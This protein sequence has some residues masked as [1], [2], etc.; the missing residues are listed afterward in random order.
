MSKDK[1]IAYSSGSQC[2]RV[3]SV[4]LR[5]P[6]TNKPLLL[7]RILCPTGIW[8]WHRWIILLVLR[9]LIVSL[10]GCV[11]NLKLTH[12]VSAHKRWKYVPY[13]YV[14][15]LTTHFF[16]KKSLISRV[17]KKLN[18]KDNTLLQTFTV[19]QHSKSNTQYHIWTRLLPLLLNYLSK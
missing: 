17:E 1:R 12:I 13:T 11:L 18:Q 2:E 15:R 14:N 3:L 4:S 7:P 16:L 6:L 8:T 5:T 19:Y 9:H 10:D